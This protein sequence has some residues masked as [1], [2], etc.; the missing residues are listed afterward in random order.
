M[1]MGSESIPHFT[2]PANDIPTFTPPAS[3]TVR[4]A[5]VNHPDSEGACKCAKCGAWVCD[6]CADLFTLN[7]YDGEFSGA[8]LCANCYREFAQ[9]DKKIVGRQQAKIITLLVATGIGALL[10]LI[11][12]ISERFS[13]YGTLFLALWLASFWFWLKNGVLNWWH[14]SKV[15]GKGASYSIGGLIG[16]LIGSA[17]IAPYKTITKI[18]ACIRYIK[19]AQEELQVADE[20]I[21][22][23]EDYLAYA[24]QYSLH[25]SSDLSSLV[26]PGGALA[27]NEYAKTLLELGKDKAEDV[28]RRSTIKVTETGDLVRSFEV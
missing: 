23:I 18:I 22:F 1:G 19:Q 16:S 6:E 5:C 3:R 24:R 11:T 9:E 4:H 20:A 7:E 13:W 8:T 21:K 17:V 10:G 12:G 26:V 15:H 25:S 28:L 27:G 2:P 14:N